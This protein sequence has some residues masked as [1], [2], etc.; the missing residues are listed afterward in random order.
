MNF[1]EIQFALRGKTLPADHG[2][3][4]YA[5][6]KKRLQETDDEL[7]PKDLP[8]EVRLCSV[9]G[10]PD[11]VGMIYLNR[12]S[13]LRLRCPAEQMQLW[14]RFLQNQVFDIRGHLV[15]LVQPRITLPEASDTLAARLV[16]FKLNSIDHVDVPRYF[17]ESCQKGLERLEVKGQVFIP[18]DAN[19]D[20]SRRTL[21]VK[22]K[23]IVGYGVVVEGLSSDDSLKLQWHGLGGRQ[24]FGCGWFYPVREGCDAA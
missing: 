15:R 5:A 9:S 16:T 10:L 20:L 12:R 22:D 13:R 23:K 17:L 14:Y 3:A 21:Q 19:G 4:L 6:V 18:S 8:S 7:L 2:Y 24:H 11:R 1:L